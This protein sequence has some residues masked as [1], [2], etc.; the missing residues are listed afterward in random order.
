MNLSN[1]QK[2]K[3]YPSRQ[4]TFMRERPHFTTQG[5]KVQLGKTYQELYPVN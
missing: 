1:V 4:I 5:S 2:K 3:V